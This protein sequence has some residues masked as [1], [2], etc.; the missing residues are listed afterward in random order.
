[1]SAAALSY[2][3]DQHDHLIRVDDGYYRFAE[4]NGWNEAGSSLGRSLWDYVA[5]HEMVKLQRLLVRRIRD[6][7]GDV[8][9]PFR[10]DGPGVRREMNIRIVARPG[11]RVVLFSARLRSEQAREFPQPLLDPE[12]PRAD[13]TLE[14]CGWCDRF[15][16]DGEWVEVEEAAKRLELF[17]RPELPA[18]SHGICPT[19]NEMLLA[20]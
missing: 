20:A 12:A 5:G 18:L 16:V 8:E 6:E 15:A 17:N 10:C 13:D 9:L 1:M 14:M 11:G 7:V 2:A 19:C 3:I 4:E